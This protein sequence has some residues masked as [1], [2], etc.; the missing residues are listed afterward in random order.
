[1][2]RANLRINTNQHKAKNSKSKQDDFSIDLAMEQTKKNT[3]K[4]GFQ[5]GVLPIS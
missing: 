2:P 3:S 4:K 5:G 1:M